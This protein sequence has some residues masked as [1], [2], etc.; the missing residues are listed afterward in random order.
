MRTATRL[1]SPRFD[2]LVAYERGEL[3]FAETVVLFQRLINSGELETMPIHFRRTA[4]A[5]ID[6][7]HCRPVE[8]AEA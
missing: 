1:P 4:A 2:D 5:L 8:L 7:G 3:T 6:D